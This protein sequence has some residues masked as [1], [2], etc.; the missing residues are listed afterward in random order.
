MLGFGDERQGVSKAMQ[1]TMLG[2]SQ[3][4][5]G[6]A[7]LIGKLRITVAAGAYGLANNAISIGNYFGSNTTL[8]NIADELDSAGDNL[9]AYYKRNA[10]GY[11]T[12]GS[13]LSSFVPGGLGMVAIKAAKYGAVGLRAQKLMNLG[14]RRAQNVTDE[15]SSIYKLQGSTA[16]VRVLKAKAFGYKTLQEAGEGALIAGVTEASLNLGDI[17]NDDGLSGTEKFMKFTGNVIIWGALPGAAV[18]AFTTKSIL[19]PARQTKIEVS[20]KYELP[21]TYKPYL[22]RAIEGKPV[23]VNQG[24]RLA[25]TIS[26]IDRLEAIP[27]TI[28]ASIDAKN[29]NLSIARLDVE[30]T[31][32][33]LFDIPDRAKLK[34]TKK[35]L[36]ALISKKLGDA[37]GRQGAL[38]LILNV[39]KIQTAGQSADLLSSTYLR[40][41]ARLDL[42]FV[43]SDVVTKQPLAS[44]NRAK[45]GAGF[46]LGAK[47][48]LGERAYRFTRVVS[49]GKD[50]IKK[51]RNVLLV[52]N[53]K[54]DHLLYQRN[55]EMHYGSTNYSKLQG[56]RKLNNNVRNELSVVEGLESSSPNA[57]TITRDSFT[58]IKNAWG[59]RVQYALEGKQSLATFKKKYP[60]LEQ[61]FSANKKD[62][63]DLM[64]G[65]IRIKYIDTKTGEIA[66]VPIKHLA[67]K[68]EF[69]HKAGSTSV[70]YV[71]NVT[72]KR[73]AFKDL[74]NFD[75]TTD[76]F[77]YQAQ[78]VIATN[79]KLR[80]KLEATD[81]VQDTKK[82]S[83]SD[84]F[85]L[86]S[87]AIN[88]KLVSESGDQQFLKIN[89]VDVP[90]ED[91]FKFIGETKAKEVERLLTVKGV[92]ADDVANSVG[93]TDNFIIARGDLSRLQTS[94]YIANAQQLTEI[95]T[96]AA[97]QNT[98]NIHDA[99]TLSAYS[100]LDSQR[101][102]LDADLKQTAMELIGH[103]LGK[104]VPELK[105]GFIEEMTN[106]RLLRSSSVIGDYG[107]LNAITASIGHFK[108]T[109]ADQVFNNKIAGKLDRIQ[110][111]I[112]NDADSQ[113]KLMGFYNWFQQQEGKFY[114]LSDDTWLVRAKY[115]RAIKQMEAQ[116]LS[117]EDVL[118]GLESGTDYYT[119]TN[120]NVLEYVDQM[121]ALN[122]EHIIGKKNKI[123]NAYGNVVDTDPDSLY[124][125]PMNFK[126]TSY[127][128]D[129]ARTGLEAHS[130]QVYRVT[131]SSQSELDDKIKLAQEYSRSKGYNWEVVE[132][133]QITEYAKATK[134]YDWAG[135][136]LNQGKAISS[137]K[138]DGAHPDFLPETDAA[139]LLVEHMNWFKRQND[140]VHTAAIEM[141]N[142][143]FVSSM[144]TVI[145]QEKYKASST[146]TPVRGA[147]TSTG[148]T[149]RRDVVGDAEQL[150]AQMMGY[151]KQGFST[152]AQ[153]N[154]T[155]ETIA[156]RIFTPVS[157]AW[158]SMRQS[159]HLNKNPN[160]EKDFNVKIDAMNEELKANGINLPIKET[161]QQNLKHNGNLSNQDVRNV[162]SKLNFIQSTLLLR[163][164][165]ADAAMNLLGFVTKASAELKYLRE[166]SIQK[167]GKATVNFENEY[168]RLFGVGQFAQEGSRVAGLNFTSSTKSLKIAA[169]RI[170]TKEGKEDIERWAKNGLFVDNMQLLSE[171]YQDTVLTT[172]A[173]KNKANAEQYKGRLDN[174]FDIAMRIGTKASD[175]TNALTQYAALYSA[176]TLAKSA[177]VGGADL[178]PF[179]FSFSRKVN[180][181]NTPMSKPRLFQGGL[182]MAMSLYQ[183]FMFHTVNNLFR[184]SGTGTA[185]AALT[186]GALNTTFF[187][188]KSV[189]GFDF[190]NQQI[191]GDARDGHADIYTAAYTA[192]PR[193]AADFMMYGAASVLLQSNLHT[194]GN[195]TP[196]STTIVPLNPAEVPVVNGL[197]NTIGSI[198]E[199]SYN[200]FSGNQ[201]FSQAILNT[202][203]DS[204]LNRPAAGLATVLLN[205]SVDGNN[206]T[207]A[208]HDDVVNW[209]TAIRLAGAKPFREQFIR[210]L[211]G[212]YHSQRIMDNERKVNLGKQVRLQF[213]NDHS[214]ATDPQ[215]LMK[216]QA[217]YVKSGG[218]QKNFDR[219]LTD[220]LVK[221]TDT[222]AT[223]L[224]TQLAR[225]SKQLQQYRT[226]SGDN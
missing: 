152:W 77:K 197:T 195:M 185:K 126:Y 213:D 113:G 98:K 174:A 222:L 175:T 3:F 19:A 114:K 96:Y 198:I 156:A 217:K 196:R 65:D 187:G 226:I 153:M 5:V 173:F 107:S 151:D 169:E 142:A 79:S 104:I 87:M 188:A 6:K 136:N 67:D 97:F 144:H 12:A 81:I 202:V 55:A 203:I 27:T 66:P 179:M 101:S 131:G 215:F 7:D 13:I 52:N 45:A 88:P 184:Y 208:F 171:M 80:P 219:W 56:N 50:G 92:S 134:D 36:R 40:N 122:K 63:N 31:L 111:V 99:E 91:V 147:K 172:K 132:Q 138:R 221:S 207:V 177:G 94:D 47:N 205:K 64:Y 194:R 93:V 102:A 180:A 14:N 62:L 8:F 69:T 166:I 224:E 33:N 161:I 176:E 190:I 191:A 4:E 61:F 2:D 159:Y 119:V 59:V 163:L 60:S 115:L 41:S 201:G 193:H 128:R 17:L 46:L 16:N 20:T 109:I 168:K 57:G 49:A 48:K 210:D 39:E 148:E 76:L 100:Y 18:G 209:S 186:F 129:T 34:D 51:A 125:P 141:H 135:L 182:G 214:V 25:H 178:Y 155:A 123:E 71:D 170:W 53:S 72:H 192:M 149:A 183:S 89:K 199:N 29:T 157:K 116:S 73:V 44:S 95:R 143:D 85:K 223:R 110:K 225:N 24:D 150:L 58:R 28:Q 130:S 22:A 74:K 32:N 86:E 106:S 145:R 15:I 117:V 200:L 127:I 220:T 137:Q 167:G 26:E 105:L 181:I 120:K 162:V 90:L 42:K 121:Q 83:L 9:G 211:N 75:E 158:S 35:N 108:N 133:K 37:N 1:A 10:D 43:D 154:N 164:D 82:V 38:D 216:T 206:S 146:I 54:H 160:V 165:T 30:E 112:L 124:L 11:D 84:M 78:R 103:D 212:R 140:L 189:P 21:Y 139:K 118:K 68:P 23:G 218:T 70:S 204:H